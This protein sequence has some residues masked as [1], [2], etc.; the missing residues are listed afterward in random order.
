MESEPRHSEAGL[1]LRSPWPGRVNDALFERAAMTLLAI[2]AFLPY[3]VI[4]RVTLDWPARDLGGP[5]D[6]LI[7]FDPRWELVYFSIYICI[8]V[9]VAYVRDAALFRRVVLAFCLIQFSC[10]AVFLAMP[11]GI[12]RPVALDVEGRFVEWGLAL[13]YTL[14]AP[15]NLF[16]SLHLGNAFMAALVIFH[17]DRRAGW[18][19][20]LWASLIGYSTVAARHHFFADVVAG[21]AVAL[22]VDRLVI[23]P[24]V[25]A[26]AGRTLLNPA[27]YA[28]AV[29]ALYPAT[30]LVL[31]LAWWAGWRPFTWP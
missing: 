27:R 26:A 13:N 31:Y 20:L 29:F 12:E 22:V 11:V 16:P 30:A 15:R 4:N 21:I 7:P 23:V 19:A 24:A 9:L 8:F 18:I 5:V 6:A 10:Y 1:V 3:F 14:D 28:L 2:G 17:C 25:A